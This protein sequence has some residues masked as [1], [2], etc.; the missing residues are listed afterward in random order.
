MSGAKANLSNW[1]QKFKDWNANRW[2]LPDVHEHHKFKVFATIVVHVGF[3]AKAILYGSMGM[4]FSL[5]LLF[6]FSN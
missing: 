1:R 3:F 6:K 5:K 2:H 4:L